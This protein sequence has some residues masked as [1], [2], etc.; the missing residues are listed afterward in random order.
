MDEAPWSK[1]KAEVYSLFGRNPR[2]NR[3]VVRTAGLEAHQVVLDVGCGPGAA[4]RGAA[5][6]VAQAIGIDRSAAMIDIA[7]R[8]SS[9]LDNVAY[10]VAGAEDLPFDPSSIDL[11][12]TIHAFHHWEHPDAGLSQMLRV[13]RPGGRFLIV[14]SETKGAHGLTRTAAD[15]VAERLEDVGFAAAHVSQHRKHL[16]ITGTAAGD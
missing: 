1:L 16:V 14:E 15:G 10:H 8:R 13:L 5:P 11:A 4:V 7:R 9:Q 12:L 6:S 2:S 3:L